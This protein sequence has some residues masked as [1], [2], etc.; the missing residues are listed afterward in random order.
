MPRSIAF[1]KMHGAGNDFVVVDAAELRGAPLAAWQIAA[2]CDRRLG[3]GAD[4]FI[5]IGPGREGETDFRMIY[6]NADGGEAEMC[7]NGARCSVAFAHG[8]GLAPRSC[9]FDT[10]SGPL[11]GVVHGAGDIEVSLPGWRDLDLA[12][13]LEGAPW[14][15]MGSCNTGVPHLV[16]PVPDVDAVDLERWGPLLRRHDRF[17]PAGTNVNWVAPRTDGDGFAIRT[18]ERGVEAET[19][20]CGTGASASAVVLC[21]LQ[22]ASS[23]VRL[24]T[25]GGD[26]LTIAVGDRPD[27]LRLRGPAATAFTGEATIHE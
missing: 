22:R 10:W 25:R 2:L 26:V 15:S 14:T 11:E 16:V 4:G 7:G 23:P 12:V 8:R 21:H 13:D 19:L 5:V 3:V 6:H 18:Y 27:D 24:H 9:R 20:A 17:A 1:T